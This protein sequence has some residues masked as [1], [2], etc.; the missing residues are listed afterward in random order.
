MRWHLR[1]RAA[2]RPGMTLVELLVVLAI[3]GTLVT[4]V[5][6]AVQMARES[7]RRAQCQSN[8]RQ[9]GIAMALHANARG[10]FP[11]GCI[12]YRPEPPE[13]LPRSWSWNVQLLPFLERPALAESFDLS[14][15]SAK[16]PNKAPAATIVAEFLCPSTTETDL[17]NPIGLWKGCAFTDYAGIYGVEGLGRNRADGDTSIQ[18]VSDESLGICVYEE[19]VA[20]KRVLDGLA[21]T[22]SIA[23]TEVRR[24]TESEWV[25]GQNIFAHDEATPINTRRQ[26]GNEVGSPHPG[27]ASV[28]F[29]DAH[30]EFVAESIEQDVLN[31]M[32]TRAGG[33]R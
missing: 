26:T 17:R 18:T 28:V 12:G 20:P 7:A 4:L 5:L 16:P 27:G 23:E 10:A 14:I 1:V 6:P 29:C 13:Q 11:V 15:P 3:I 25:S 8:L 33:E 19:P 9:L 2:A 30:V 31:A 22:A 24:E 21:K 32:L